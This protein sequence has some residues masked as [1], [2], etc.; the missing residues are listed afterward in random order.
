MTVLIYVSDA[1]PH[2]TTT[3]LP[4]GVVGQAYSN[5]IYESGGVSPFTWSYTGSLPSGI[6]LGVGTG[7]LSGTSC[8]AGNYN[9]T[10][11]VTDSKSNYGTQ[12][13]MLQIQQATTT[14]LV[15]SSLNPSTYGQAVIFTATVTPQYGC[16]PTGTV[17]FY[18]GATPISSAIPL[19]G[20]ATA[21]FTTNPLQLVGGPNS[22][23]AVYSGDSN[24]YATGTGGSTA[25]VLPQNVNQATTTT[26]VTS[27]LSSPFTYGQV[28]TFTAM[29]APQ[30]AGTPTGS[31]TFKDGGVALAGVSTVTLSGGMAS[32]STTANQL[33]AGTHSITAVYSGDPNFYATGAGG[34]TAAALP[35]VVN[36]APLTATVSGNESSAPPTFTVSVISYSAF[37]GTDTASSAVNGTLTC[38]VVV[39]AAGGTP[40][41]NPIT[42]TGLSA[43]NYDIT[44]DYSGLAPIV[45]AT[46]A[47]LTVNVSG[48]VV[49]GAP[50]TFT[51]ASYTLSG[52]LTPDTSSVVTGMLT[53]TVLA[54]DASN[55]YPISCTGLST[56]GA[57][58]SYN[59]VYSYSYGASSATPPTPLT[60]AVN[61]SLNSSGPT[62]TF[63]IN[64]LTYSGF[65]N[66][67][68]LSVVS[69][70]LSCTVGPPPSVTSN[71][72]IKCLGL[73]ASN[74]DVSYDYTSSPQTAAATPAPL[75]VN[76]TGTNPTTTYS[77]SGLVNGNVPTVV[78]GT[79]SCTKS[80]TADTSGNYP[81]SCSG[82]SATNYSITYSYSPGLGPKSVASA[83][84]SLAV[85]GT[86]PSSGALPTLT[87][88]SV[89]YTGF[90]NG[91]TL[92]A[93]TGTLS[94]T[95]A[96]RPSTAS[97][98][99]IS[100]CT[101][102]MA[103]GY[104]NFYYLTGTIT[105][106]VPD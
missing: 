42:C 19:S 43:A 86:V 101:G 8:V 10:A 106:V 2:V 28:V 31:V 48:T 85:S 74:Y 95:L 73:T 6:T 82:L 32:F 64:S 104:Y 83:P 23:I 18:D 56:T 17:T 75:I 72:P 58:N 27:S 29:V 88:T 20:S 37:A 45:A 11:K 63:T 40:G 26:S 67:D 76:V 33:M 39:P 22:I 3:T 77:L 80:T 65:V 1:S 54:L 49:T 13:L 105:A 91:D 102:L 94:C 78:T 93:I 57:S 92:S 99:K 4:A 89:T 90:I 51:V 30:Y 60:V 53:C 68:T 55:N 87:I 100:S 15:V 44:Y 9:F 7:M 24:F 84:L 70:T 61:G 5:T 66:T 71:Y 12:G 25:T 81:I 21:M 62:P 59:I 46:P 97:P 69:G 41:S 38:D 79:I 47:T 16:T 34:S 36:P 35:Q 98:Y 50:N 14:T 103:P 96:P 52:L